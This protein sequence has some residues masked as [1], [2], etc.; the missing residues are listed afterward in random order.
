MNIKLPVADVS[1]YILLEVLRRAQALRGAVPG[2][3][4][5]V[6]CKFIKSNCYKI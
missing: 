2:L 4:D 6:K 5:L 3:L 1:G